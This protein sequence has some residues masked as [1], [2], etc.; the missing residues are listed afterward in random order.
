MFSE[1]AW[2]VQCNTC[3]TG[4]SGFNGL[5]AS[6]CTIASVQTGQ[7]VQI[8]ATTG[9]NLSLAGCDAQAHQTFDFFTQS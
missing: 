6:G 1:Q 2:T 4:A 7:C 3:N 9:D 8:D 5:Y